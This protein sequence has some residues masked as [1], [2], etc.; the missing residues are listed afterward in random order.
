MKHTNE[1]T[2]VNNMIIRILTLCDI[3]L[4]KI[5]KKCCVCSKEPHKLCMCRR[6]AIFGVQPISLH[7]SRLANR[8]F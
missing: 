3:W 5:Y 4:P 7:R 6:H 1:L 8:V 2:E